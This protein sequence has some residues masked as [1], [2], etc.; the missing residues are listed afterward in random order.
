MQ[1]IIG[2][3]S[4]IILY[5][6]CFC[7]L[8]KMRICDVRL[9]L[10]EVWLVMV[11]NNLN[12][13]RSG[14]QGANVYTG[15]GARIPPKN[16]K[17]KQKQLNLTDQR[18]QDRF[19]DVG[20]EYPWSG[21]SVAEAWA[22]QTNRA[23][24]EDYVEALSAYNSKTNVLNKFLLRAPEPLIPVQVTRDDYPGTDGL[25][26]MDPYEDYERELEQELAVRDVAC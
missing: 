7:C 24:Q 19:R 3:I 1:S 26:R 10:H 8:Y 5:N 14:R 23:K 18:D 22:S 17:K 13:S 2:V 25:D 20:K 16:K 15:L 6:T 4:V 11:N 12:Q 9:L 21:Y